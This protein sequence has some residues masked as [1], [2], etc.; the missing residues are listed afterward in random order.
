MSQMQFHR[1]HDGGYVIHKIPA[2]CKGTVSAW[3][4]ADGT[5]RESEQ[6]VALD[7]QPR[8]VKR[9]GPLWQHAG[10]VGRAWAARQPD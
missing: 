4:A 10:A 3:F 6:I 7:R 9:H 8:P 1:F 5:L 2:P